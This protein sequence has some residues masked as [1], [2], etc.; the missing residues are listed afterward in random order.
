[1]EAR[2]TIIVVDD[3]EAMCDSIAR[4]V[5]V[6][7][8]AVRCFSSAAAM[9]DFCQPEM[10]GCLILD[11]ELPGMN[12]LHLR[13][14]LAAKGCQQPF[15]IVSGRADIASAVAAMH[16]G[17]LDFIEKPFRRQHLLDRVQEA[18]ARDAA[19]RR[20][21]PSRQPCRR[22]S[23]CLRHASC[24]SWSWWAR[25]KSPRRLRAT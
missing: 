3:D 15:I 10:T 9:L 5:G 13:K 14:Q 23:T 12:G 21:A 1:M 19:L 8:V 22:V 11:I 16:Q 20:F 4:T 6:L 7:D 17:A 25:G 24:R 2:P 18:I